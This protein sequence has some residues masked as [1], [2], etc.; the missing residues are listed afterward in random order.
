MLFLRSVIA[1]CIICLSGCET[2]GYYAQATHGQ[3]VLLSRREAIDKV[4]NTAET[5]ARTRDQLVLVK[6]IKRFAREELLLP[7]NGSFSGYVKLSGKYP[8]W[9]VVATPEFSMTPKSWCYPVVGCADYRGYFKKTAA[10]D[11]AEALKR[12][13]YDVAIGGVPAYSTLGWFKDPVLSSYLFWSE[14]QL[15]GVIFHE[16]AHQ[17][18]YIA[19]DSAFNES[20][21]S[22]VEREG[23][24][25][26]LQ[27]QNKTELLQRYLDFQEHRRI[28][29]IQVSKLRDNLNTVYRDTEKDMQ[30]KR[31]LKKHYFE[32]FQTLYNKRFPQGAYHNWVNQKLN[33]AHLAGM[34]TYNQWLERILEKIASSGSLAE[35]YRE[36]AALE[37]LDSRQRAE[38]LQNW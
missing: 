25:R 23:V 10:E 20:F 6:A 5:D 38:V 8:V 12:Q 34:N 13:G 18:L 2:L 7:D 3:V 32:E 14:P 36:A 31:S 29:L 26:W 9:S 33:N 4:I 24:R 22:A 35:F 15:A 28:F 16:L 37:K 1:L 21:A 27:Q 19:G 30:E 11:K 17:K